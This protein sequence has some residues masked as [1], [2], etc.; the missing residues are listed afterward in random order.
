MSAN[1]H[2]NGGTLLKDLVVPDFRKYAVKVVAPGAVDGEATRVQG[3]L[4][5]DVMK[6]NARAANFR[7]FSPDELTSNRWNAVLEA[8]DRCLVARIEPGDDHVATDGRVL[9][10]LSEHQCEGWL[11]GYLLTGRHGFFACY[12]AFI[13]IIDS[14]FNQHAKW[15]KSSRRSRGARRSPRSTTPDVARLAAGPQRV[16]APGPGIPRH[17]VNKKAG[18]I[19]VYLPPD[20]NTLLSVDRPLPAQP[21]LRQRHRRGEA[22]APQWLSMDEAIDHCEAGIGVWDWACSDSRDEPDVVM[23]CCGDVP[24]LETLAAVASSASTSPICGRVVNVV[25]PHAPSASGEHPHGLADD[26][27]D[28]IFT[29]DTP[30]SSRSTATRG[31]IHRLAYRRAHHDDLHV[32]GYKEEGRRRRPST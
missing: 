31:S 26:A 22:A 21:P 5:R 13:H 28:A 16:L 20:A 10:V 19:R 24:T 14:M 9:E 18:V 30:A 12:E 11:E 4:L 17:V 1:P 25:D 2:A 15:L 29:P 32:R 27:F 8:T 23:A 7:I 3:T 6:R